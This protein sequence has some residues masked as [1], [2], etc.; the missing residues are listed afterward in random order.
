MSDALAGKGEA[1]PDDI[2]QEVAGLFDRLL[3]VEEKHVTPV[4]T[5]PPLITGRDLIEELRLTP[6]PC[7]VK[8]WSW[9]KRPIWNSGSVPV[10]KPWL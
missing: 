5:A 3:Q 6:G 9:W 1:S 10:P 8:S 2:E 4:R 7:S